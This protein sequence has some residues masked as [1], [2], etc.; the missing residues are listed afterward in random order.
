MEIE[1]TKKNLIR[2][3]LEEL[4]QSLVVLEQAI[5]LGVVLDVDLVEQAFADDLPDE[6]QDQVLATLD[7]VGRTDVD[8]RQP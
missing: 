6:T 7:N 1:P 3:E 2:W 5:E 8:Y 4:F